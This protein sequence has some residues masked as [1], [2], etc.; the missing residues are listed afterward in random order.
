MNFT[1]TVIILISVWAVVLI[2]LA[3]AKFTSLTMTERSRKAM[4][5]IATIVSAW[6]ILLYIVL[7]IGQNKQVDSDSAPAPVESTSPSPR[8]HHGRRAKI[9]TPK[10][11]SEIATSDSSATEKPNVTPSSRG[12]LVTLGEYWR[13]GNQ[14]CC[15]GTVL[16]RGEFPQYRMV[17]AE[18]VDNLGYKYSCRVDFGGTGLSNATFE[19]GVTISFEIETNSA[20]PVSNDAT[21]ATLLWHP[22]G[23]G[24][25]VFKNL[26][27]Q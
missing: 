3:L 21:T 26:S 4:L 2:L 8:Q 23:G 12:F 24:E 5:R 9:E 20:Y 16:N 22:F 10:D 18:I 11:A 27:L 19:P 13:D 7:A 17:N 6:L 25:T 14:I 1:M 15:S